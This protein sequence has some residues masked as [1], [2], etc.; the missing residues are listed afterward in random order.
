[1]P[2][3]QGPC[4]VVWGGQRPV[5]KMS[6]RKGST[7]ERELAKD[8]IR[9]G[10]SAQ[11][12]PYSGGGTIKGDLIARDMSACV[13]GYHF[14][15]KRCERLDIPGWLRQSYAQAGANI[16]TVIFRRNNK[17]DGDPLGRSHIVVPFDDWLADQREL[18]E[19]RKMIGTPIELP[20]AAA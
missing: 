15:A 19:L 9:H 12:T 1:M 6:R 13:P 5:S 3:L 7:Y 18:R 14:E 20:G 8:L 11:R 17:R 16:P 10:F 2:S 4:C